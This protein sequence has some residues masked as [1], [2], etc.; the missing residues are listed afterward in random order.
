MLPVGIQRDTSSKQSLWGL[1][2]VL[3][4][5]EVFQFTHH[6]WNATGAESIPRD[7]QEPKI[8][9]DPIKQKLSR[10]PASSVTSWAGSGYS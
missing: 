3:L 5:A 7:T 9:T 4:V 6:N 2:V 1:S 10:N 8:K